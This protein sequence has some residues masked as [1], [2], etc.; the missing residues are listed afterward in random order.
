MV[1]RADEDMDG[2][3]SLSFSTAAFFPRPKVKLQCNKVVTST[4]G[5]M[6]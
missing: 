3:F 4:R 1:S 5:K 6:V 2:T